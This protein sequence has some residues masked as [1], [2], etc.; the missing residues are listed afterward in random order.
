MQLT[1]AKADTSSN[2]L[3][4]CFLCHFSISLTTS[5]GPVGII[6]RF[7][8]FSDRD[9]RN[10]SLAFLKATM[11]AVSPAFGTGDVDRLIGDGARSFGQASRLTTALVPM[12]MKDLPELEGRKSFDQGWLRKRC[13]GITLF[14]A[15][16]AYAAYPAFSPATKTT[17][18][19]T[20]QTGPYASASKQEILSSSMSMCISP[21]NHF[22]P[23]TKCLSSPLSQ[24]SH[25]RRL[26]LGR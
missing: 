19:L 3:S 11:V 24:I 9:F 23:Y 25:V 1:Q 6:I 22:V 10:V 18:S 12:T 7:I 5:S 2:L 26:I 21:R 17:R 4:K 8:S 13:N 15:F 20:G 16:P 14:S